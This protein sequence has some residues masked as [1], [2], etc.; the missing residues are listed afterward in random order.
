MRRKATIS[1]VHGLQ[2]G[3]GQSLADW[4]PAQACNDRSCTFQ[5]V[6]DLRL[7]NQK[8][9]LPVR[10]GSTLSPQHTIS[11]GVSQGSHLEPVL[12]L[13]FIKTFRHTSI[14]QQSCMQKMRLSTKLSSGFTLQ[15]LAVSAMRYSNKI[16]SPSTLPSPVCVAWDC[17]LPSTPFSLQQEKACSCIKS[18]RMDVLTFRWLQGRFPQGDHSTALGGGPS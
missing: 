14:C 16:S 4:P 7:L 12:F 5:C 9:N 6:P 13:V 17:G 11:A 2:K 10:V 8:N 1:S 18:V 3:V 15:L